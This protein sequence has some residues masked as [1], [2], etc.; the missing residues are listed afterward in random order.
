[1]FRNIFT[2]IRIVFWMVRQDSLRKQAIKLNKAGKIRERDELV[3]GIVPTW[4]Q[5]VAK[6]TG[7]T[8]TAKGLEK[9][10]QDRAVVIIANHQGLMD[11]PA[12]YGYIP[13][14]I[15]FIC[16]EIYIFFK[17]RFKKN[18]NLLTFTPCGVIFISA[19]TF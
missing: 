1:M 6:V 12:I 5:Y 11:I 9:I 2:L 14:A 10:P 18:E 16:F 13:K 19:R 7:T 15:S 3:F 4:A 17:S 8:V